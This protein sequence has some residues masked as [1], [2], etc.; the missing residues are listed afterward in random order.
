MC[1]AN[2][3]QYPQIAKMVKTNDHLIGNH[4]YSHS[5]S[6]S[7]IGYGL[8][9][10][11]SLTHETIKNILGQAPRI[12]RA[13]WGANTLSVKKAVAQLKY[14]TFQ[15]DISA[16]DW[17]QPLMPYSYMKK[18]VFKKIRPGL[19]I[20]LHD[21]QATHRHF[22]RRK[23]IRLLEELIPYLKNSG[24]CFKTLTEITPNP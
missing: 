16:L 5:L 2:V 17:L 15:W 11:I 18:R 10:E 6:K 22:T 3:R 4:S 9:K 14:Q 20:L 19:I 7:L 23:T 24:Y 12:F 1:G 13:P 8:A 21:G